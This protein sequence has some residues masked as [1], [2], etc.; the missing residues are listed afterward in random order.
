MNGSRE[1]TTLLGQLEKSI[2]QAHPH[3]NG[4][5]VYWIASRIGIFFCVLTGFWLVWAHGQ[6]RRDVA[7]NT[8]AIQYT[9]SKVETNS[10]ALAEVIRGNKDSA[11][12]Q[13]KKA[14]FDNA[15][16][17]SLGLKIKPPA[18]VIQ[19]PR[20]ALEHLRKAERIVNKK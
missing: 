14:E 4:R 11:I 20:N 15:A 2:N 18:V 13:I 16:A 17:K 19:A 12:G 3:P 1:L 5:N 10:R 7:G 6:I 8:A 9:G